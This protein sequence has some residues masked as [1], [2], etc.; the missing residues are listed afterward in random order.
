LDAARKA[1]EDNGLKF[2]N[3][4][5]E[6]SNTVRAGLVVDSIPAQLTTQRSGSFVNLIVSTGPAR[7]PTPTPPPSP[8]ASLAG[9]TPAPTAWSRGT[10]S[11]VNG[12]IPAAT[13]SLNVPSAVTLAA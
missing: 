9:S 7:T 11:I 4:I 6:S 13:V 8:S 5:E 12:P 1:L 10:R 2:G 3:T